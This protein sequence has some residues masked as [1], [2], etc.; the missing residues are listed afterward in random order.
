MLKRYLA[1]QFARPQGLVGTWL[2]APW[3][4]RIAGPSNRLALRQMEIRPGDRVLE[5]GFGGGGLI[6]ALL[7]TDATAVIGVDIS[8]EMVARATRR[9]A[10]QLGTGGLDL[11][12][13]PVEQLP[14]GDATIDAAVSVASL[15]FW[16]DPA[17]AL[18]E[19]HRVIRPGGRLVLCFEPADELRKWP[20]HLFGFRLF[21]PSEVETLVTEAGFAISSVGTGYGRNPDRFLCLSAVRPDANG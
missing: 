16:P 6:A 14:L 13:A 10:R 1:R 4:D 15:Y 20:G 9:F 8:R 17:A 2:I 11:V 7:S 3:L 18:A 5:I 19:L 21:E 12:T